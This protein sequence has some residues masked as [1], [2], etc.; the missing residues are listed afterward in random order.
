MAAVPRHLRSSVDLFAD[1]VLEQPYAAFRELRELG[2]AAFLEREGVWFLGR[3]SVVRDALGDW[4]SF[5]SGQGIGLNAAINS[6]WAN[7]LICV[8]PPAHTAMRKLITDRIGPTH[9][10]P[11][12]DTIDRRAN[13]LVDR[14]VGRGRFD[15]VMELAH[16]LPVNILMDLIGW[17]PE[18]RSRLLELSDGSFDTC[19]PE[20]AR[21]RAGMLKV[22]EMMR[23]I[24]E[25]YDSG[26]LT[27]G[28]FGATV[29][30][31]ARRGEI[32]REAAIGML[33]GYVVAAFD[34][35]IAGIGSGI[36]LFATHPEQWERVRAD[37]AL[38]PKAF[39]EILRL[40]SPIQHF[41]RVATRDIDLGEGVVIPAGARAVV[42]YAAAN[43]DERQFPA[44]DDFDVTRSNSATHLAFGAGNHAC[45]GQ[46]LAKLEAH[47][48]FKALA[49]RVRRFELDG[50]PVRTPYN[51]TR[52]FTRVPTRTLPL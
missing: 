2:P 40:E 5:S 21:M 6:A 1:E 24:A 41:S 12:E 44:P 45:A 15:A 22:D 35:T 10:K 42:S 25:I 37:P 51:M 52:A 17:P 14:L 48:V 43:R 34:T 49:R 16:D 27:P 36:W 33:A 20:N 3:F 30:D 4:K 38:V 39:N 29:A 23:T 7:A 11:I 18:V 26:A 47:A 9:L 8:D 19:G 50:P 28:G 13:E 46:G 31:S 32:P